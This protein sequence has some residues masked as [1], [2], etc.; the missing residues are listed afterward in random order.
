MNTSMGGQRAHSRLM[1]AKS[2]SHSTNQQN[3]ENDHSDINSTFIAGS[4][5]SAFVSSRKLSL[6]VDSM[7]NEADLSGLGKNNG[8]DSKKPVNRKESRDVSENKS[9]AKISGCKTEKFNYLSPLR[10]ILRSK[11]KR[12]Q[13]GDPIRAAAVAVVESTMASLGPSQNLNATYDHTDRYSPS[14]VNQKM[15]RST[16]G[17]VKIK[18]TSRVEK[19]IMIEGANSNHAKT[20]SRTLPVMM[21]SSADKK[22]KEKEKIDSKTSRSL[23]I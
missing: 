21:N 14:R 9:S 16:T 10:N 23:F 7:A 20:K 12:K 3:K 6:S 17:V 19:E 8:Q 13:K 4:L 15:S 18:E 2:R 1:L 11:T 22:K 5:A